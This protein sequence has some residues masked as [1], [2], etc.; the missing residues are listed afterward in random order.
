M[1]TFGKL[2]LFGSGETSPSGNKIQRKILSR[3]GKK[4]RIAILETPAGFQPNATQVASEIADIFKNSLPEFVNSVWLIPAWKKGRTESPDNEEILQP[5]LSSDYIFLGPGSP[6]YTVKQL[7]DSKALEYTKNMWQSGASLCLSSAAAIA[8]GEYSLPVYEIFKVGSD[9]Y[10]EKGLDVFQQAGLSL[11]VIPHWNN[12]EGGKRLDTRFCFMG[13]QRFDELYRLLSEDTVIVGI[14]ENTAIIFDFENKLFS[15]EGIGN[16]TAMRGKEQV[17]FLQGNS[18][19]FS[20]LHTF[21]TKLV[22]PPEAIAMEKEQK[23]EVLVDGLSS[24]LKRLLEER[25]KTRKEGDFKKSDEIRKVFEEK[26]FL[27]QDTKLGQKVFITEK[28]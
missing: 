27:L 7:Q 13:K 4:Q 5:L 1:G 11:S 17:Q 10:W 19:D 20:S 6:T 23:N 2:I 25:E 18:Y 24:D 14:D 28:D 12:M 22:T 16:V 8:F 26:G 3:L 9:L 15:I 21:K